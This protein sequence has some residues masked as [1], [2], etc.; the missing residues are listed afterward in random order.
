MLT[1]RSQILIGRKCP[2]SGLPIGRTAFL[3]HAL[4]SCSPT[5]RLFTPTYLGRIRY[6]QQRLLM[7]GLRHSEIFSYGG[8]SKSYSKSSLSKTHPNCRHTLIWH[9]T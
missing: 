6:P 3:Q 5:A 1:K 7:H 4:L 8:L 2:P 9:Y